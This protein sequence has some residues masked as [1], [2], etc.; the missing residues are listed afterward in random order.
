MN[1]PYQ[2]IINGLVATKTIVVT[3]S[4]VVNAYDQERDDLDYWIDELRGQLNPGV[5]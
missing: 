2:A 5:R 1:D 3:A 4:E